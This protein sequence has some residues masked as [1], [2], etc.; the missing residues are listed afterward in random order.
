MSYCYTITFS[1]TVS[2]TFKVSDGIDTRLEIPPILTP[3]A[4]APLLADEL[5][6]RGFS[7]DGKRMSIQI[8]DDTRVSIDPRDATVSIRA[9]RKTT[10]SL[11]ASVASRAARNNPSTLRKPLGRKLKRMV[12]QRHETRGRELTD[13]L[14][15]QLPAIEAL[16][17]EV[18]QA[19]ASRALK[20]RAA[21]LGEIQAI[22]EDPETGE[23]V[24]KV[25]V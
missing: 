1:E 9:K 12:E 23:L 11:T 13:D 2:R 14:E 7:Q 4:T 20:I 5:A 21:E 15:Q 8:D 24:I 6:A 25:K 22:S 17:D 3:E 16:L 10:E 18:S 19:V